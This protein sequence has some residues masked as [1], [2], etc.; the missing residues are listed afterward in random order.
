MDKKL[1]STS[2]AL[3]GL[4]WLIRY[5]DGPLDIFLR[6]RKFV[7]IDYIPEYDGDSIVH[8]HEQPIPHHLPL[9]RL[10]GCF[11]CLSVWLSLPVVLLV[12]GKASAR[13][14]LSLMIGSVG[15]AGFLHEKI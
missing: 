2:A 11:W 12:N 6:F 5:T 10:V 4:T 8:I 9:A 7:G 1:I 13:E 15:I 14:T 3:F